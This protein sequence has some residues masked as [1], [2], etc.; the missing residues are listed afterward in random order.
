MSALRVVVHA[1]EPG[2]LVADLAGRHA[3]VEL[4]GCDS[5]GALPDVVASVRPQ[6]AYSIGMRLGMVA[7]MLAFPLAGAA[8][9]S[10]TDRIDAIHLISVPNIA[11][12]AT[13]RP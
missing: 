6:A 9:S 3:D 7:P 11:A 4:H 13:P 12:T 1:A 5:Y 10:P 2:P 8:A